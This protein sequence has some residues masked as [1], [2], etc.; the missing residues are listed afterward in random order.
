MYT[1]YTCPIPATTALG[2]S[3]ILY[4]FHILSL[5]LIPANNYLKKRTVQ[6]IGCAL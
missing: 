3:I 2:L 4:L 5:Q 1:A 6:D